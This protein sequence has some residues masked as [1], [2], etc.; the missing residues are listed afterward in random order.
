MVYGE[1][2]VVLY[3]YNHNLLCVLSLNGNFMFWLSSRTC[4]F[5]SRCKYSLHKTKRDLT[6]QL[7]DL[8]MN[9]ILFADT[10]G[11][12]IRRLEKGSRI[13]TAIPYDSKIIL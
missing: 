10:S 11:T 7:W 8:N 13:I 6:N 3:S 1:H 2:H 9:E 12:Y 4:S 5:F